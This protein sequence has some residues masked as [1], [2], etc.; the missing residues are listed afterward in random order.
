[1]RRAEELIVFVYAALIT[2]EAE[3]QTTFFT[4]AKDY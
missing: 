3:Y 2:H 4:N 1:M